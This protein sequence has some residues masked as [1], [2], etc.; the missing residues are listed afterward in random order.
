MGMA[1]I[2]AVHNALHGTVHQPHAFAIVLLGFVCFAI[3]KMSVIR[4]TKLVSFGTHVMT[5]DQAN[6][7]RVGYYLMGLGFIFTFA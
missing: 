4:K 6:F 7:Y 3:V 2:N 1:G 5:D